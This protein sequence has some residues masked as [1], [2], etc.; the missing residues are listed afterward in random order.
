MGKR[1]VTTKKIAFYAPL[2]PPDHSI[3]SGDLLMAQL[4]MDCM[5]SSGYQVSVA[6]SLRAFVKDPYDQVVLDELKVL[7][8]AE[9][10]RLKKQWDQQGPPALWFCYHPYYKSPDLI[11]PGLCKAY[12]IP[13]ITAEASYSARRT[14]GV[15]QGLQEWVASSIEMAAVNI[16]FTQRDRRGLS[17]GIPQA[18]LVLIKPFIDTG[19][20]S[21]EPIDSHEPRLV[22]VAM[23]RAGDKMDS[24]KRLAAAL[25]KLSSIPWMLSV[26]GDGAMQEEVEAL[27]ARIPAERITW[28]GRLNRKDIATLF[29]QS[30]VYVLPGCGEAYGLAYLEAQAAGLPVVAYDTAGVPEVVANGYSGILTTVSDDYL[31]AKAIETLLTDRK[32]R[33]QMSYQARSYVLK[34]SERGVV[35]DTA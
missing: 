6:S 35:C 22:T 30:S 9:I 32:A 34:A 7:A 25:E 10:E 27:F 11:G 3:P 2:K 17:Q 18:R 21:Q 14:Q 23:M 5:S 28:H 19:F 24:Y 20:F 31:Y 8:Q 13:Y 15:W 16:C 4:L 12:G 26:V 33:Q 29:S 1:V